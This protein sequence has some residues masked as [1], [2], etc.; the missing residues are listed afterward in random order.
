MNS[1]GLSNVKDEWKHGDGFAAGGGIRSD[2]MLHD[3]LCHSRASLGGYKVKH[4]CHA[5]A[6]EKGSL[7][8][9]GKMTFRCVV[10]MRSE[11]VDDCRW[12]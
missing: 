12:W 10:Y 11:V 2:P 4:P 7:R 5:L 3:C 6:Y 1:I 9:D 8:V